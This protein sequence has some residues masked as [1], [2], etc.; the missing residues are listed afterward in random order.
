MDQAGIDRCAAHADGDEADHGRHSTNGQ[1][2]HQYARKHN[3][4][5][6]AHHLRVTKFE[7]GK[8]AD[9]TSGSDADEEQPCHCRSLLRADAPTQHQEGAGP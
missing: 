2:Q 7:S 3:A 1:E 9:G 5:A 6:N 4:L 8:A